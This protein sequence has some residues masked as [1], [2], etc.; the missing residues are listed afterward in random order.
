MSKGPS[1]FNRIS[2]HPLVP[3]LLLLIWIVPLVQSGWDFSGYTWFR[4]QVFLQQIHQRR[5][6][7]HLPSQFFQ[8]VW[9]DDLATPILLVFLTAVVII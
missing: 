6:N 2:W 7:F 1:T 3:G 9:N 4:W 5:R 8:T